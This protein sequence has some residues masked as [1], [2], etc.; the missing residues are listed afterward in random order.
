MTRDKYNEIFCETALLE[1]AIFPISLYNGYDVCTG[2]SASAPD[3]SGLASLITNP[4]YAFPYGAYRYIHSGTNGQNVPI[5]SQSFNVSQ[6]SYPHKLIEIE[7][8]FGIFCLTFVTYLQAQLGSNFLLG[9]IRVLLTA[10]TVSN[11]TS[12]TTQLG[13]LY[14]SNQM[15]KETC[16]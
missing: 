9:D 14:I 12:T 7:D 6:D 15:Y 13:N 5:V 10:T 11:T 16:F 2:Q 4:S 3:I 1:I 8:D